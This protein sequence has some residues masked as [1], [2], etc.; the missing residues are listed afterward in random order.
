MKRIV[1]AVGLLALMCG[2]ASDARASSLGYSVISLGGDNY[3]YVYSVTNDGSLGSGVALRLFDV[4]F[5]PTLYDE[6]SLAVSTPAAL[7]AEW[8]QIFLASAPGV[9][10]AYDSLATAGGIADGDTVSGFAVDFR[11][12]GAGVPGAQAYQIFD[13]GSFELLGEG[14]TVP[15]PA[16]LSLLAS[17]LGALLAFRTRLS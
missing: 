3:R 13:P 10:A 9:S 8:D 17:G 1:L 12:L 2:F 5:D 11:W 7:G 6:A 15:E 16:A 4:F 14:V